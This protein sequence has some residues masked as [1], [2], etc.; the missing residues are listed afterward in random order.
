M[1]NLSFDFLRR[2]V[3]PVGGNAGILEWFPEAALAPD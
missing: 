1:H 3:K 2:V